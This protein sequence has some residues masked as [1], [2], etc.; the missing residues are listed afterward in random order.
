MSGGSGSAE[1]S[2]PPCRELPSHCVL[3]SHG[4]EGELCS[5]SSEA[6]ALVDRGLTFPLGHHLTQSPPKNSLE[7][8]LQW[9]LERHVD[10]ERGTG[11]SPQP[12][13]AC[14]QHSSSSSNSKV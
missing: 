10:G 1:S 4:A 7:K 13:I 14:E 6:A 9:G 3:S 5:S 8:Q 12:G 11:P 2:L